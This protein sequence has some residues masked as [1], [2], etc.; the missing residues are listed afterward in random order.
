MK[1]LTISSILFSACLLAASAATVLV[2][3]VDAGNSTYTPTTVTFTPLDTPLADGTNIVVDVAITVSTNGNFSTNLVGGRYEVAVGS[4][5]R[6][7]NILVPPSDTN[8]YT[9]PYLANLATNVGTFIWTNPPTSG[10]TT[11][12]SVPGGSTLYITNGSIMLV[13]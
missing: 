12:Y 7:F 4:T 3:L 13:Q 6:R 1:R 10:A 5:A 8:S 2:S 9:L 11:N